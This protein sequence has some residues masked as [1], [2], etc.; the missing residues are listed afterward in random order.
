MFGERGM[1]I[2]FTSEQFLPLILLLIALR[3]TNVNK[4]AYIYLQLHIDTIIEFNSCQTLFPQN[5]QTLLM[6]SRKT[7]S[8]RDRRSIPRSF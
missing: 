8:T 4:V 3:P 2:L 1:C 6:T 5:G 7:R